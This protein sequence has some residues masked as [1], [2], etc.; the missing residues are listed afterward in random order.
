MLASA[1]SE[2]VVTIWTSPRPVDMTGLGDAAN[3]LDA[4]PGGESET[5]GVKING[6]S[7]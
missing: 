2:G 3:L 5:L 7:Y 4:Y 6:P 1:S